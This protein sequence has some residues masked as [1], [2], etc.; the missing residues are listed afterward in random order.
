MPI[1]FAATCLRATLYI[2]LVVGIA[3]G[4][5]Y[6]ALTL[7][8]DRFSERGFIELAQTGLLFLSTLLLLY[9]RAGLRELPK[10]SLLLARRWALARRAG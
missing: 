9:V 10:V 7:P 6:E 8:E 3:Q 1:G 2:L 4:V 5:Y